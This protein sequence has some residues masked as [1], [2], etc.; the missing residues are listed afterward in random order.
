MPKRITYQ[1]YKELEDA[2]KASDKECN[3]LEEKLEKERDK[4]FELENQSLED[5][6]KEFELKDIIS[7]IEDNRPDLRVVK[8]PTLASIMDFDEFHDEFIKKYNF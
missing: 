1:E 6:F 4:I 2:L 8:V 7:F 5:I 3:E